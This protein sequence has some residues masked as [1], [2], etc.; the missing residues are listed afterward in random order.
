MNIVEIWKV[1]EVG[2]FHE[3]YQG[4]PVYLFIFK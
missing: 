2:E 3:K 4:I 1:F